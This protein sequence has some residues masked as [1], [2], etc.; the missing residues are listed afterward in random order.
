MWCGSDVHFDEE[1]RRKGILNPPLQNLHNLML[2]LMCVF[3]CDSVHSECI[4]KT[5]VCVHNKGI[6]V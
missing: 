6:D 5:S 3:L 2:Y 4:A 1:L